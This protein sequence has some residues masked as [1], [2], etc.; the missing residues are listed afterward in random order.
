[1][2]RY[3]L[4]L[5][6]A[7]FGCTED[8][9]FSGQPDAAIDA[10][11]VVSDACVCDDAAIQLSVGPNIDTNAL[12]EG[13]I[14]INPKDPRSLIASGNFSVSVNH[15]EGTTWNNSFPILAN[16]LVDPSVAFD[17]AGRGFWQG[18]D[19]YVPQGNPRTLGVARSTDDGITW[20]DPV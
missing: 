17:S 11:L 8:G 7:S 3:G 9:A 18:M 6:C 2:T 5:L 1:M 16:Q 4:L 20:A 14:A 19:I 15:D 13:S 12:N 10:P